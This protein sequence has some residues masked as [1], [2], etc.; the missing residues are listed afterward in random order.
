[1]ML[2]SSPHFVIAVVCR[3]QLQWRAEQ[4]SSQRSVCRRSKACGESEHTQL[5]KRELLLRLGGHRL[6]LINLPNLDFP[7]DP[8]PFEPICHRIK[9]RRNLQVLVSTESAV[10][11]N[12]EC[13]PKYAYCRITNLVGLL[14]VVVRMSDANPYSQ[15]PK[16]FACRKPAE[17]DLHPD[18]FPSTASCFSAHSSSHAAPAAMFPSRE[19]ALQPI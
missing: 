13:I 7:Y 19:L 11:L 15:T 2:R 9:S 16:F 12:C 17:V 4:L 6:I 10:A 18:Q 14:H 1:M 5:E 3:E 8:C